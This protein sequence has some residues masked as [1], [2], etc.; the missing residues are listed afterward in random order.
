[1]TAAAR[2]WTWGRGDGLVVVAAL[3]AIDAALGERHVAGLQR[4]DITRSVELP[5]APDGA[6]AEGVVPAFRAFRAVSHVAAVERKRGA[7]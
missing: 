5:I 7:V 4:A 1:M 3:E 6:I 2:E